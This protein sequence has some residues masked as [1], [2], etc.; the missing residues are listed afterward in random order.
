MSVVSAEFVE[1]GVTPFMRRVPKDEHG[2]PI[3][4]VCVLEEEDRQGRLPFSVGK[5]LLLEILEL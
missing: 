5:V 2:P 4:I 1:Q 3:I